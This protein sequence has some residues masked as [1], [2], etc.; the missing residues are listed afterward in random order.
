MT[1][2]KPKGTFRDRFALALVVAYFSLSTLLALN[3]VPIASLLNGAANAD[4][5]L[6]RV[7]AK[8]ESVPYVE[9]V[10]A[11]MAHE[12][13][14]S[15]EIAA[16][17]AFL[18]RSCL[19]MFSAYAMAAAIYIVALVACGVGDDPLSYVF[20]VFRGRAL[21]ALAALVSVLLGLCTFLAWLGTDGISA[22][23]HE[24]RPVYVF[25]FTP[26]HSAF[27]VENIAMMSLSLYAAFWVLRFV[28]GFLY[29]SLGGKVSEPE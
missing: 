26:Q 5:P 15:D 4:Q 22:F 10:T 19:V 8:L 24:A 28:L 11:Y 25:D 29:T 7:F 16:K 21:G 3:V 14:T 12:G 20:T 6:S 1:A 2:L 18:L 9:R 13:A 17:N 23:E 27:I